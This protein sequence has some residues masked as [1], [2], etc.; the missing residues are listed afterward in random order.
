MNCKNCM[1]RCLNA[2]TP[3]ISVNCTAYTDTKRPCNYD[4]LKER[5]IEEMAAEIADNVYKL[6][7]LSKSVMQREI[8]TWLEK[9]VY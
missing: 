9:E 8:K 6:R 2:G 7:N 1:S 5:S 4:K 3:K